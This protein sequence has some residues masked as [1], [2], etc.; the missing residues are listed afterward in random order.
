MAPFSRPGN[1]PH[2]LLS[3]RG[4]IRKPRAAWGERSPVGVRMW[5]ERSC[6][7]RDRDSTG[8]AAGRPRGQSGDSPI[9]RALEAEG[10]EFTNGDQPGVRL[11][12][13]GGPTS[14]AA[15]G[16]NGSNDE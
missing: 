2:L 7:E 8:A 13:Q 9:C 3:E 14:I 11:R 10:V 4:Q 15:E 5:P 12:K 6:D 16:L 1:P